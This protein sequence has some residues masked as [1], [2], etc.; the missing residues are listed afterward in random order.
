MKI[1]TIPELIAAMHGFGYVTFTAPH[2]LNIAV[3]RKTPGTFDAFDDMICMWAGTDP[4][5]AARCTADP[6]KA[7]I[8]SPKRRDGTAVVCLG[9][10]RSA[11]TFG[12]H[13]DAYECF[14]PCKPIPVT[15]YKS[16]ADYAAGKGTLSTSNATQIHRASASHESSSVG[17]YSE[18]CIV[19]A[20]PDDFSKALALGKAQV[21]AGIGD[22]FS[23]TVLEW[24]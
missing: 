2:D 16:A 3:L 12:R 19:I 5:F 11:Y 15:R 22:R 7:A 1:P 10:H 17:A 20:N 13:H 23:V 24:A 9:Q 21:A 4:L 8:D 18:G 14:V 6:G